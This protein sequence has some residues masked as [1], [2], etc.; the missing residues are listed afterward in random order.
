MGGGGGG[1][2]GGGLI[3]G[4]GVGKALI[5]ERA[6]IRAILEDIVYLLITFSIAL[7]A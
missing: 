4:G 3:W 7:I 1:G 5:R 6:V 2:G